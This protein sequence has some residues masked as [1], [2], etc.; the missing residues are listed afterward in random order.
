M[1]HIP[2]IEGTGKLTTLY[3]DGKPFHARAGEI[4]NSSASSLEYM[5][6]KVWPALRAMH[7]NCIVAPIYWECVEPEEGVYDFTLVDGLIAQARREGV[8]LVFL[9]FGLWKNAASTYVP[10]W[11]ESGSGTFL[12]GSGPW[13]PTADVHGCHA[14]PDH[15]SAVPGCGEG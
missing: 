13:K 6:Q 9:W 12:A 14:Q 8:K 11:G 4:H 10:G 3:V 2:Y 1:S 7:L 15:L 5:E